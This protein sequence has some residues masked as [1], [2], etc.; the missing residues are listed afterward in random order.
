MW[1]IASL[2]LILPTIL[3]AAW[4]SVG[5]RPTRADFVVAAEE[6]RTL[7]PQRVSW[8]SE[9]TTASAMFEGLTRLDPQT[10]QP[11]PAVA[12]RWDVSDDGQTYTFHLRPEATWSDGTP[13]TAFDFRHS[14]L[15]LLD[16]RLAAQY[17][18][19]LFVVCGAREYYESAQPSGSADADGVGVIVLDPYTLRVELRAPCPYFLDLTSFVTLAPVPRHVIERVCRLPERGA[20]AAESAVARQ[21]LWTRPPDIVCNGAFTM[22]EWDFKRRIALRRNPL[23]WDAASIELDT[24]EILAI[25]DADAQLLAY[26]TGRVD[27][28]R[29][30]AT[31]VARRLHAAQQAG[32]RPDFHLGPRFA[33]YFYR[34]NCRRPPLDDP[35]VRQ[36]LSLAIDR[37]AICRRVLGLGEAPALNYVPIGATPHMPRRDGAGRTVFYAPPR[38]LLPD[39]S[40][41]ERFERA[42]RLLR[43]SGFA[44]EAAQRPI[45]ISYA[46]DNRDYQRVAEAL[47][48]TWEQELGIRVA[49]G[50]MEG[51]ALSARIRALQYD[52][53]RSDWF[54]DYLDPNTFLEMFTSGDGQNRTG[55]SNAEYDRRIAAAAAEPD[56]ARRYAL[57]SDAERILVEEDLPIIP[58]FVRSGNFLLRTGFEGISDNIRD[59]APIQRVRRARK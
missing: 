35:R 13:L 50:R 47:A 46:S 53:A 30:M 23:Y 14:W 52:V 2:A 1:R 15:R 41:N 21:H 38:G 8:N 45:E 44:A 48:A 29:G 24:I 33:T 56:D 55:W 39:A 42:R 6:P 18:S 49:H 28:I 34:V 16:R 40:A 57:L 26:E 4:L 37:D 59:F 3:L 20:A 5:R 36:A 54:G 43:E 17:A 58:L 7:D 9:I 12:Q 22:E 10:L 11:E 31:P 32:R 19:L 27:F 51:K 25:G